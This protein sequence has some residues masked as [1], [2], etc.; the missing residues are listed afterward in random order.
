MKKQ[1]INSTVFIFVALILLA[2]CV[3]TGCLLLY[4]HGNYDSSKNAT[5]VF[6]YSPNSSKLLIDSS[7]PITDKLGKQL[8]FN[9]NQSKYGYSEFSI[10]SNI[11]GMESINYEIYAKSV[12]VAAELPTD[13]VKIYLTDGNTDAAAFGYEE[14]VPTYRDLKVATSDPAGKKIYA[15]SLKKGETANFKLRMWLA[16]AY[17]ITTEVRSFGILL[18]VKVVD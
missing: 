9:P 16:D 13:Y 5:V 7:M 2:I 4:F 18:Y 3:F 6:S 1:R 15:G 14:K 10:S 17:P 12:G 8:T 11:E